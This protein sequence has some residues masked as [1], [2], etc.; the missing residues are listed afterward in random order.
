MST[1]IFL[2][3][4]QQKVRIPGLRNRNLDLKIKL[5]WLQEQAKITH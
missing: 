1:G 3:Q 2:M 4:L 5:C